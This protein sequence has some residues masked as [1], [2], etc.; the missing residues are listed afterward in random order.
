MKYFLFISFFLFSQGFYSQSLSASKILNFTNS[1]NIK[2]ISNE[3][4]QKGFVLKVRNKGGFTFYDFNKQEEVI[5]ITRNDELF[6]VVYKCNFSVF[7]VMKSKL[8]TP[9]FVYSYNYKNNDYY[10]NSKMRIG[11]NNLNGIISVF[12]PLKN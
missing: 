8:L 1:Q 9:D 4:K 7:Q 6:M 12:K 2:L 10:E 5:S 3:L 11:V